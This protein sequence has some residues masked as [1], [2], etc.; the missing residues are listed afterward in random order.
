MRS[1]VSGCYYSVTP[2]ELTVISRHAQDPRKA[3]TDFGIGHF[4]TDSTF[5]ESMVTLTD[6]SI[7]ILGDQIHTW[8][9]WPPT[10]CAAAM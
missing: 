3:F 7:S 4:I 5:C 2:N 1:W 6:D 9:S 10:D 8:I